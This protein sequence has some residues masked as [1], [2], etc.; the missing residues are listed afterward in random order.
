MRGIIPIYIAELFPREISDYHERKVWHF[1]FDQGKGVDNCVFRF[2]PRNYRGFRIGFVNIIQRFVGYINVM[3]NNGRRDGYA[4]KILYIH[5][6]DCELSPMLNKPKDYVLVQIP[7][8]FAKKLAEEGYIKEE[9][10]TDFDDPF[11]YRLKRDTDNMHYVTKRLKNK[12][13]KRRRYYEED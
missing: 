13:K 9:F 7:R 6:P 8:E 2:I 12:T 1:K 5:Q 10:D 3:T 4:A 11:M